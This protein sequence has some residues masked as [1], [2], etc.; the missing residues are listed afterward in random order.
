L[1][2]GK[3][4]TGLIS[5]SRAL[6]ILRNF[7]RLS[8][9]ALLASAS[10]GIYLLASDKSLWILA[11]SH[12]Y[13]LVAICAI[14]IVL[15]FANLR[16]VRRAV[17]ISTGWAI[18]TVLLQL[19]DIL[20]APQY[21]M[22]MIY[23]AGYLFS[24]WAFDAILAV[25]GFII[26]TGLLARQYVRMTAKKKK[27]TY[28]EMG[29]RNSRRDFLQ[30]AGTIGALIALTGVLGVWAAL[31]TRSS[32]SGSTTQTSILP[33]GAIANKNSMQIESPVYFNYPAG[34]PNMLLKRADGS[35]IALSM[36][37]THVCCQT[38][39]D[40]GTKESYCPCH[41]SVFDQNGNVLQGPASTPLPSIQLSV[42]ANGYIYPVKIV[43]SGPCLSGY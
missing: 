25:Q 36:L 31:S 12:A 41:G 4:Q 26:V 19:G 2:K 18:L 16:L 43:G 5:K 11:V 35:L 32:S 10:F 29:F 22:T 40:P 27:I 30:I 33:A 23:F 14:D 21:G 3:E 1:N 42:D 17:I 28:F 9:I 13:G 8:G 24:L 34:Y 6:R 39:Y 20:T 38:Q 7:Q 37:C 15:G